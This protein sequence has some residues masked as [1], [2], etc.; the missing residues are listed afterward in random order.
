MNTKSG[1]QNTIDASKKPAS[2]VTPRYAYFVLGLLTAINLLNYIDRQIVAAVNTDIQANLNLNDEQFGY[3]LSVLIISYTLLS[4]LFG[5]LGDKGDRRRLIAIG[6]VIWSVATALAGL[7]QSYHQLLF[8]RSL[9]GIGEAS[10]A[11]VTPSLISDVFPKEKRGTALGIFFAAIPLGFA[12]G[13]ILGGS[14]PYFDHSMGLHRGWRPTMFVVGGPGLLPA[15]VVYFFMKE[16]KRGGLDEA[17]EVSDVDESA[18]FKSAPQWIVRLH[19]SFTKWLANLPEGFRKSAIGGYLVDRLGIYTSL[20]CCLCGIAGGLDFFACDSWV[21][22]ADFWSGSAGRLG[23]E[24]FGNR[25]GDGSGC[26]AKSAWADSSLRWF[27]RDIFRWSDQRLAA[28][29]YKTRLFS[30]LRGDCA[31]GGNSGRHCDRLAKSDC[32]SGLRVPCGDV[33]VY[34]QCPGK[35]NCC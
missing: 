11:T 16:P 29:I 14:A 18:L 30:G 22:G 35:C 13:Y 28:E 25:Q 26:I 1:A 31:A 2:S 20:V 19:E 12:L 32:L 4:P 24:V 23:T 6:I 7:A 10:Y 17:D 33:S 34:G 9:I 8:A 5:R 15:A 27:R 3:V 21:Y